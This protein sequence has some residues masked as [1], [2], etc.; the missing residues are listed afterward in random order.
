MQTRAM[1][2]AGP[3]DRGSLEE[4]LVDD[5]DGRD[6]LDLGENLFRETAPDDRYG[7]PAARATTDTI[8]SSGQPP[9]R[10]VGSR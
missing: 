8:T 2:P 5:A 3:G 6:Q 1:V 9:G 7:R 4:P 10:F